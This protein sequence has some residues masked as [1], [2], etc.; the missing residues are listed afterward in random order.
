MEEKR[1]IC[2]KV[3]WDMG[4]WG[5]WWMKVMVW[6]KIKMYAVFIFFVFL[7]P[8]LKTHSYDRSRNFRKG[9]IHNCRK[10]Q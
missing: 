2:R 10:A 1:K 6:K 7:P 8:I 3:D 5:A 4:F 9:T